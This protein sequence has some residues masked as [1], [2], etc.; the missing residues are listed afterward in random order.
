MLVF[1]EQ[2][3]CNGGLRGFG[4]AWRV[5]EGLGITGRS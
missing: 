4:A 5:R 2:K 3:G 1:S